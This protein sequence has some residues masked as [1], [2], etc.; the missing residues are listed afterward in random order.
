MC[1]T[2]AQLV[3]LQCGLPGRPAQ[4][5]LSQRKQ[6]VTVFDAEHTEDSANTNVLLYNCVDTMT[7]SI[8]GFQARLSEPAPGLSGPNGKNS[9]IQA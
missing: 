8:Q 2:L 3:L 7:A 9:V 5:S 1:C 6:L 4:L